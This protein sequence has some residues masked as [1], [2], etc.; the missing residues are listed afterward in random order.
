MLSLLHSLSLARVG[1]VEEL[2][3]PRPMPMRKSVDRLPEV[4]IRFLASQNCPVGRDMAHDC[5][6]VQEATGYV[7][8]GKPK[9]MRSPFSTFTM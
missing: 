4:D 8:E 3:G 6:D 2:R 5:E 9:R 7:R 1:L